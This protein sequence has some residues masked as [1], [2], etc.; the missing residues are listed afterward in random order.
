MSAQDVIAVA[1]AALMFFNAGVILPHLLD[2]VIGWTPADYSEAVCFMAAAQQADCAEV[3]QLV[4]EVML[5]LDVDEDA[6]INIIRWAGRGYWHFDAV[7]FWLPIELEMSAGLEQ[8]GEF[9]L[10]VEE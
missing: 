7:A 9:K 5:M 1:S 10:T 3:Q 6:A 4:D 8:E 2:D